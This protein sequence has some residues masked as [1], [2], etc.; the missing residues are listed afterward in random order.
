MA[1][2]CGDEAKTLGPNEVIGPTMCICSAGANHGFTSSAACGLSSGGEDCWPCA[3]H[4]MIT[5]TNA[6]TQW[7]NG[8]NPAMGAAAVASDLLRSIVNT[9]PR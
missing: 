6:A 9:S 3:A 7:A 5:K 2:G 4:A 8:A 1:G